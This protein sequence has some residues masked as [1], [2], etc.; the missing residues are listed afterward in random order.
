MF[1]L[2]LNLNIGCAAAN[3]RLLH[4]KTLFSYSTVGLL[5]GIFLPEMQ[6]Q[7][8]IGK[9][10]CYFGSENTLLRVKYKAKFNQLELRYALRQ[11]TID[12][13]RC[14]RCGSRVRFASA[15]VDIPQNDVTLNR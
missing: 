11:H 12:Y 4:G 1:L 14:F 2:S 5:N 6:D 15:V 3:P 13:K 10:G 7:C 8:Y 9:G